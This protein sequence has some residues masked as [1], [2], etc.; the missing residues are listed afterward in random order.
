MTRSWVSSTQGLPD[1]SSIRSRRRPT[2]V[3]IASRLTPG[4]SS[5]SAS[6]RLD[7]EAR[8]GDQ[9]IFDEQRHRRV[10]AGEARAVEIGDDLFLRAVEQIGGDLVAPGALAFVVELAAHDAEQRRLDVE[11]FEIG[12]HIIAVRALAAG[13]DEFDDPVRDPVANQMRPRAQDHVAR[14]PSVHRQ[15]PHAVVGDRRDQ[16]AEAVQF[17]QEVVAQGQHDLAALL[18]EIVAAASFGIALQRLADAPGRVPFDQRGEFLDDAGGGRS[19]LAQGEDLLEL[20]EDE[21]RRHQPV[22]PAPELGV[23]VVK[24]PP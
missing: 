16:P 14:L 11:A 7:A 23:L 21:H 2:S 10:E 13:R 20:I 5:A 4:T 1:C 3:S 8:A 19:R 9:A 24:K 18:V 15:Q 17:G 22:A 6:G 12:H